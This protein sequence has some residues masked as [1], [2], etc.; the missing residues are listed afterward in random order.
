[1]DDSFAA[2]AAERSPW[3]ALVARGRLALDLER[4]L[5]P[6][7]WC[8]HQQFVAEDL[9]SRR[10]VGFAELWAENAAACGASDAIT[11]QPVVFNLCVSPSARRQGIA[12]QLLAQCEA[13]AAEWGEP[14]LYLKVE[15]ENVGAL[16]LYRQCGFEELGVRDPAEMEAWMARW[17]GGRRPLTLMRK[18]VSCSPP[19][20]AAESRG[21][22]IA[23]LFSKRADA[24][25]PPPQAAAPAAPPRF[26]EL[27]V[28]FDQ[29]RRYEARGAGGQ[30]Y[31][32]FALLVVRNARMLSPVYGAIAAASGVLG[33]FTYTLFAEMARSS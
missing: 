1:L 6:W 13:G 30:A 7:D 3:E 18:Q 26:S 28:S 21:S 14:G 27:E 4:R 19:A 10:I 24:P 22:T 12:S 17:K 9:T 16:G 23:E 15:V 25:Q 11:P 29:V 32:W 31:L 20:D 5:T 8:R 33:L 2:N